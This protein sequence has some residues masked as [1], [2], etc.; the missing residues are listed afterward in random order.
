V[1]EA[2]VDAPTT[3][4]AFAVNAQPIDRRQLIAGIETKQS[5]WRIDP[6]AG[7]GVRAQ[8]V[9]VRRPAV[10]DRSMTTCRGSSRPVLHRT[11]SDGATSRRMT[12]SS[13]LLLPVI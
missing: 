13:I 7:A 6:N 9:E 2:D 12:S 11:D 10:P 3:I 4:R 5:E 1:A 8:I